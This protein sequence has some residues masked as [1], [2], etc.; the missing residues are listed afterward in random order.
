MKSMSA[1]DA[2]NGFG[3]LID[4]A[5]AEPVIIEKHG[6]AVVVVLSTEEY[7]RLCRAD[8]EQRGSDDDDRIGRPIR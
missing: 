7:E 4:T 6:R 8:T 5:R 3:R 1:K 2:K